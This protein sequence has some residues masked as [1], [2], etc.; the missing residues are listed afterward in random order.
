ML[1]CTAFQT[2]LSTPFSLSASVVE[3]IHDKKKIGAK[4]LF[5]THYHELTQLEDKLDGVKNYNVAVKKRGDDITFLRKII[6][7]GADES[8]GIEVAA[9]AGVPKTVIKRAKEILSYAESEKGGEIKIKASEKKKDEDNNQ[10][11]FG[12]TA[13]VTIAEELKK[14]DATTLTPIEALNKLYELSNKAKEI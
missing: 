1:P 2:R 3:Y 12:Y 13:A 14:L 9:L 4:T 6:P 5:A 8:Y 7:G 11:D 10:L